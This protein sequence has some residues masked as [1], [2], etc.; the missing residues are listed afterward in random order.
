MKIPTTPPTKAKQ[1][2]NNQI[3]NHLKCGVS[4]TNTKTQPRVANTTT[5]NNKNNECRQA[6]YITG[7]F[8]ITKPKYK[9]RSDSKKFTVLKEKL[10]L[11]RS[12]S[13]NSRL[14]PKSNGTKINPLNVVIIQPSKY[15]RDG[16]ID[17]K[18]NAP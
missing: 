16:S 3:F 17:P 11:P 7:F 6:S 2:P 8:T 4:F 18:N 10:R 12:D 1:V 9:S 15:H 14:P 5:G 13:M